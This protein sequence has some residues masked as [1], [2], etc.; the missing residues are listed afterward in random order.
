MNKSD[1]LV[2]PPRLS[3]DHVT[4]ERPFL[5]PSWAEFV[6]FCRE[7]GHGEI[8]NLKIQDGLPVMAEVVRRKI[9]FTE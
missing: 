8:E 3:T 9:K 7:L 2:K 4:G 6:R 5:H 1:N